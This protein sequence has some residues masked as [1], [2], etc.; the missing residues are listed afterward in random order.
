MKRRSFIKSAVALS[1]L[2][3]IAPALSKGQKT[4]VLKSD[5]LNGSRRF[6]MIQTYKLIP[7]TGSEGKTN[8]WIPVPEDTAFQ[9]LKNIN[10]SGD[11]EQAYLTANNVYAAKTLFASWQK[12]TE[13]MEIKVEILIETTDWQPL[14]N[15]QLDKW[16]I[17]TKDIIFPLE[18]R[19]YLN[20]TRHIPVDGLVK[21]TGLK[22][23][24]DEKSPLKQAYLIHEWVRTNMHRDDS[25]IGCGTGDVGQILKSGN[26][27][28]KC[29]DI[30]SVFVALCRA[31]GIPAREMFGIRLGAT[32][33]LEKY[34]KKAFGSANSEGIA[35]ISGWQHC[36]AMFWLAGFGWV[37][38]DP[39]DVTK[40]RLAEKKEN[41][42]PSVHEVSEFLF[43]NWE[44]N[45]VGFNY[46]R[47][48]ALYPLTEQ[49]D[50][51]NFGYPYAEVDGDPLNFYEPSEFSYD[52]V[53]VEQY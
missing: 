11:Y 18:V 24:G 34:S 25:V 1:S 35:K 6:L 22:I 20:A 5:C 23:I 50:L 28:G 48:F 8:L 37:P 38:A 26:L 47:D 30:N 17:P 33:L 9:K 40:M 53:S 41:R 49:G 2:G 52:Y 44:M 19:P 29:T 3:V 15:G 7:P 13:P 39:A 51:N 45:W 4:D 31:C 27:G 10:F 43:G 46:A 36:R 42:D 21:E 12:S 16:Q 32:H 14:L